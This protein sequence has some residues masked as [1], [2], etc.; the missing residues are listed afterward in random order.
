MRKIVKKA[1]SHCNISFVTTLFLIVVIVGLRF[2]YPPTNVLSW[3]VFGYY[4]YLPA[5][6]IYHDLG[7]TN[8]EWL[9]KLIVHYQTTG[10]LY[11]AYIGPSGQW[12]M[13]YSMGMA[14]LYMPFF[15]IANWFAGLFGF[16]TDGLSLPYQYGITIG[17][18]FY[19]LVGLFFFR[20][21]L[22]RFF[23]DRGTAII[24]LI[25]VL[26]TNYINQ[27][28]AGILLPHNFL[29]TLLAALVWA[30]IKWHENSKM[31]YVIIIA[32]LLGLI[33]L[34]RPTEIVC[35][36]I[37][38]LWGIKN[39]DSL[40]EKLTLINGKKLEIFIGL[41]CFV[42][43][44]FP[45]FYYW[46]KHTGNYIFYSY[47]NPGEGLDLFSPHIGNFLFSFRKGWF[48]YTPM[49]IFYMMGLI[50]LYKRRKEIFLSVAI[51]FII[52]VYLISSWSCWWY[53]GGCYSQRAI[54][55]LYVVLAIGFGFFLERALAYA[56]L[57]RVVVYFAISCFIILN[58]FQYWQFQKD[59]LKHDG[60]TIKYYCAIFGK[61]K[62]PDSATELLLVDRSVTGIEKFCNQER[63]NKKIIGTYS[64]TKPEKAIPERYARDVFDTT[65]FCLVLDSSFIYS[66][67]L[68]MK[69][70]DITGEYYAWIKASV[71]VKY[72]KSFKDICPALVFTFEHDGGNYK[73]FAGDL[74]C[75][76]SEKGRWKKISFD[77]QTPEVR[78]INDQLKVYVWHR[79]REPVYL[80]N[81]II[82]TYDP[83]IN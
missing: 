26:G 74:A 27:V 79:G 16:P 7:L 19:T 5:K 69:Y 23:N 37:P 81:L 41:I 12:V 35:L 17:G 59:I 15:L 73:Y 21:I 65:N 54:L 66:P 64:F 32:I 29:F 6:F 40:V 9:N 3:D 44:L 14:V 55:S 30:T 47:P 78:D 22:L 38:L 67:G 31:T 24:L 39:K 80:R 62:I 8:H 83:I 61:T 4:L 2:F 1:I 25:T 10:T 58:L 48:V 75:S 51:Y 18:L 49:M 53:A 50:Y 68:A 71:E 42:I 70:K 63:Y 60:V 56:V 45:Q 34:V 77:Y 43:V 36:L 28:T 33:T 76:D 82:E 46:K 11:Q 52:S 72:E 13:K 57:L 20:Q